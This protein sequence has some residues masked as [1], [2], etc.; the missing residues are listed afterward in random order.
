M[1]VRAQTHAWELRLPPASKF[2]L[3]ALADHAD[4]AGRNIYP[5]IPLI[6]WKTGY[7]ERHVT[8][9]IGELL[10]AGILVIERL[11]SGHT[12]TSYRIDFTA[13]EKQASHDAR[14]VRRRASTSSAAAAVTSC[15][16]DDTQ[17]G[18]Q[19]VTAG[20]TRTTERG[21][22]HD[23]RG[24]TSATERGDISALE[25]T[26]VSGVASLETDDQG[27]IQPSENQKGTVREPPPPTPPEGGTTQQEEQQEH[28]LL[29]R[30]LQ[31]LAQ[32]PQF[33]R[34]VIR[35]PETIL[36]ALMHCPDVPTLVA[37]YVALRARGDYI[38]KA[39]KQL[40]AAPPAVGQPLS[41]P[42]LAMEP[43]YEP[44]PHERPARR[45]GPIDAR[46][47]GS[48]DNEDRDLLPDFLRNAQ[49]VPTV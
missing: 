47:P 24:V 26:S 33:G 39:L 20:V 7:S 40:A 43:A 27:R 21:D 19:D 41:F 35:Y 29:T 4:H 1:S 3:L 9:I 5:G 34:D 37:S 31:H 12:P 36:P 28:A 17:E 16:P 13:G 38:G 14:P 22:I 44:H 32:H 18:C 49:R 45:R 48:F 25:E 11:A 6:A 2:V 10:E 46:H 8:R 30:F 15:H 23:T 42:T